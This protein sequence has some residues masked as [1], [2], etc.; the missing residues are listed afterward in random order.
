MTFTPR[1]A[2]TSP[3]FLAIEHGTLLLPK[4]R[5][6]QDLASALD[7]CLHAL[8]S[9][10]TMRARILPPPHDRFALVP[11][12]CEAVGSYAAHFGRLF[13]E[14]RDAVAQL[15]AEKPTAFECVVNVEGLRRCVALTTSIP[16]QYFAAVLASP[17]LP[18]GLRLTLQGVT[19]MLDETQFTL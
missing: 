1:Q 17:G 3:D 8:Q 13:P 4:V 12:A 10:D 9:F 14:A 19:A 6:L 18:N 11:S 7:G 16:R 15:I 2:P 5:E